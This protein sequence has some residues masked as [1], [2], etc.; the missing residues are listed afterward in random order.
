MSIYRLLSAG[1]NGFRYIFSSAAWFSFGLFSHV[2]WPR[3]WLRMELRDY[4]V[5]RIKPSA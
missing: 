5:I 1:F 2:G 3:R 4:L